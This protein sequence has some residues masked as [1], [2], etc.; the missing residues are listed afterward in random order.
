[1]LNIIKRN[2]L[3]LGAPHDFGENLLLLHLARL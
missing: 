2:W 3:H 1:M